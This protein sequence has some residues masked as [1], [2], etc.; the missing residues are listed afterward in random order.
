M[1]L[2]I[3]LETKDRGLFSRVLSVAEFHDFV[4][5]LLPHLV[6]LDQ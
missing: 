5:N 6:G 2:G 4:E 3:A 1:P